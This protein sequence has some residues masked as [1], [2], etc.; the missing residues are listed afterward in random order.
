MSTVAG[1]IEM[2]FRLVEQ[3][4]RIEALEEAARPIA[5]LSEDNVRDYEQ[6]LCFFCGGGREIIPGP[7]G[8]VTGERRHRPVHEPTCSYVALRAVLLP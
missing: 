1:R 8:G 6:G 3:D 7:R 5:E 4:R 2:A